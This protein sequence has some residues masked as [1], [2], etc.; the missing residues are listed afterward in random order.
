MCF[1][2]TNII[3][4]I[5]AITVVVIIIV[6]TVV[7]VIIITDIININIIINYFHATPKILHTVTGVA[8]TLHCL[9]G[10]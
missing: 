2:K 10:L 4:I 6:I 9:Y 1:G 3:I 5:I 8:L 7:I